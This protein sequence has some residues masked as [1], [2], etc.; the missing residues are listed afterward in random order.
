MAAKEF[1]VRLRALRKWVGLSQRELATKIGV[2]FTYVSKIE[3]GLLPPPSEKVILRL[4]ET[5]N[6]DKDELLTLAGRIPSD[7]AEILKDREVLER[8]RTE[9]AEREE[10]MHQPE[11]SKNQ[12]KAHRTPVKLARV[13]VATMGV[14]LVATLLWFVSPTN[15]TAVEANNQGVTYNKNGEYLKAI[16]TL[17]KAIELD[18]NMA[19]AYNNRAW[20]YLELGQYEQAVADCNKAIDLDPRLALAYSNRGLAYVKL[21]HYEQALADCNKAIDLD[22]GLGLAYSNRGLAYIE[23]GKYEEAIAD[24]DKAVRLDPSLQKNR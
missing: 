16:D 9:R 20:S 15:I 17:N 14:A 6:V 10:A 4:A 19:L 11:D 18:S 7:I 22:P 5:L 3:N 24:F 1:G 13:V 21:G 12:I 23:L 8:L 2:D